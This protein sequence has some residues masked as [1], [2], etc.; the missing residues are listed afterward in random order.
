MK[1]AIIVFCTGLFLTYVSFCYYHLEWI[2]IFI[3]D[4]RVDRSLVIYL[5]FIW[6]SISYP[7]A[8]L[9]KLSKDLI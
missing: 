7:I 5:F 8:T 9:I 4:D 1:N 3:Q 2:N 6:L